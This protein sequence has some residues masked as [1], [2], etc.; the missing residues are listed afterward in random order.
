MESRLFVSAIVVLVLAGIPAHAQTDKCP[1]L[2]TLKGLAPVSALGRK[3]AP[4]ANEGNAA[5]GAN[6]ALTG[7]IETGE[8]TQDFSKDFIGCRQTH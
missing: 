6:Y 4:N 8:V 3:G 5:L 1:N 7:G 2:L